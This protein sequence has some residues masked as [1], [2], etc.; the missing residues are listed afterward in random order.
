M[1]RN[2]YKTLYRYME[3]LH[4]EI[5][6]TKNYNKNYEICN[7]SR[8]TRFKYYFTISTNFNNIQLFQNRY[9]DQ[10]PFEN[11]TCVNL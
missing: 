8:D 4:L 1:Q 2:I 9:L 10:M 11:E 5:R 3:S 6:D 7:E